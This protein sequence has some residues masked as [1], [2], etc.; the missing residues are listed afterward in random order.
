MMDYGKLLEQA[1]RLVWKHKFLIA[2][3]S[4]L[5]MIDQSSSGFINGLLN[6]Q[7]VR[8]FPDLSASAGLSPTEGE[9]SARIL[10]E[11]LL[12]AGSNG[13][14]GWIITGVA[15]FTLLIVIGLIVVLA[16]AAIIAGAGAAQ[17][18][19]SA[20]TGDAL[21]TAWRRLWR[22]LI[23]DSIPYIP[24]TIALMLAVIVSSIMV[25]R[26]GGAELLD[27]PAEIRQQV[28]LRVLGIS[29][30]ITCPFALMLVALEALR[31]L[32]DRACILEDTG[33]AASYRRAWI[34]LRSNFGPAVLLV[35]LQLGIG[36]VTAGVLALPAFFTA[37]CFAITPL[38]WLLSGMI[39][40]YVITVWTLAWKVWTSPLE[41]L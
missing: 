3:G 34:V 7:L 33:V 30:L 5:A 12:Y 19:D 36:I 18:A 6:R 32:A 4:V 31:G 8:R 9:L 23:I 17:S 20:S 40:A 22:L 1:G 15:A 26:A 25:Q 14:V 21:Q 24:I 37:Y 38:L 10:R 13:T 11:I 28:G 16:H 27:Q 35:L 29:S 2:L 41:T 39:S